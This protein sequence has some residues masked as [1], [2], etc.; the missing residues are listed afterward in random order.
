MLD[1]ERPVAEAISIL[2]EAGGHLARYTSDTAEFYQLLRDWA[3][4][5][6]AID[7]V[8]P[9]AGGLQVLSDLAARGR[10]EPIIIS[11]GVSGKAVL[12]AQRFARDNGLLIA[13]VLRRPLQAAALHTMLARPS[14]RPAPGPPVFAAEQEA[15]SADLLDLAIK[16]GALSVAYQPKFACGTGSL[17]GFEALARWHDP[18][19]GQVSPAQFVPLAERHG[20]IAALTER[21][22]EVVIPWFARLEARGDLTIAVNISPR[23]AQDSDS[24]DRLAALCRRTHVDPDRVILEITETAALRDDAQFLGQLARLRLH[25]FQLALDDFGGARARLGSLARLLFTEL[26]IDRSYVLA[27][28]ASPEARAVVES[29]IALAARAGLRTTAEGVED[30]ATLALLEG[31]GADFAQGYHLGM[32]LEA[33]D[34][35]RLLT[36]VGAAPPR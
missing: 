23:M 20:L 8:M 3:P 2:A 17:V 22:V 34:A 9:A 29:V 33:E 14:V 32:P 7:L 5:H 27:A 30:A 25:G 16:R 19:F 13:G 26:K 11:S 4:T 12:D 6:L 35:T 1:D 18:S 10:T 21:V 36:A 15:P 28:A 24:V 31:L